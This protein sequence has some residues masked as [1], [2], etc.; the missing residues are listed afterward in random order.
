MTT[1]RVIEQQLL[2]LIEG[3]IEDTRVPDAIAAHAD[4]RAGKPVTKTDAD[5][6]EAQLGVPMRISKR[7][8]MTHVVW[9][10]GKAPNPWADERTILI[11]HSDTSVRWPSGHDLRQK[12]PAY[13]SAR[14]ERN[15]AR[16]RLLQEHATLRDAVGSETPDDDDE[17]T[18]CRA[19]RAIAKLREA[20]A[21]LEDL[22]AYDQPLHV[23]RFDVEKLAGKE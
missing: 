7:Y 22:I 9:A 20:R 23:M 5:Q 2:A 1:A 21:A 3:S 18:I 19:A 6:L 17:S 10:V 4:K 15:T 13:F 14:D 11:A 8:G 12:E 16:K